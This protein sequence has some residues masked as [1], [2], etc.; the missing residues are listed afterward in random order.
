M[1]AD[2]LI[3]GTRALGQALQFIEGDIEYDPRSTDIYLS[4]ACVTLTKLY[5]D[6]E[7]INLISTTGELDSKELREQLFKFLE[8]FIVAD[9]ALLIS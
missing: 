1:R 3:H 7:V 9:K 8:E 2:Y 5:E 6:Q 4:V